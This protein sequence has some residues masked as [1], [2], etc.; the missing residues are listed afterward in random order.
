MKWWLLLVATCYAHSM[1]STFKTVHNGR[2]QYCMKWKQDGKWRYVYAYTR[3]E[4]NEKHL[5]R[6]NEIGMAGIVKPVKKQHTAPRVNKNNPSLK[7]VFNEYLEHTQLANK[8]YTQ[9]V[10]E[11]NNGFKRIEN[12]PIKTIDRETI[13]N[14]I[15]NK[16]LAPST[17]LHYHSLIN[18]IFNY[19]Y[20]H[21]IIKVKPVFEKPHYENKT[22]IKNNANIE[23]YFNTFM[24]LNA[25]AERIE[26][27]HWLVPIM[28]LMSLGLRIGEIL[29]LTR[30]SISNANETLTINKTLFNNSEI[31]A[32]SKGN[33]NTY[34]T[35]T[36]PL[37][38]EHYEMLMNIINNMNNE[39][40]ETIIWRNGEIFSHEHALFMH[41]NHV[42]KYSYFNREWHKIQCE[43]QHEIWNAKLTS[44]NYIK[45]HAPRHITASLMAMNGIPIQMAQAILGHMNASM[46]E[47]YTHITASMARET[48]NNYINNINTETS[49]NIINVMLNNNE[50]KISQKTRT[51]TIPTRANNHNHIT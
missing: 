12:L 7:M 35:R 11:F 29:A 45:P 32:G 41:R 16:K 21:G 51:R 43:Y 14:I 26:K 5:K 3:N 37:P 44:E 22:A 19:A 24:E 31:K 15:L 28:K 27:W 48:M 49:E 30:E 47:Y 50:K 8:T 40:S 1:A 33:A 20:K 2:E 39:N 42:M 23:N 18:A 17:A 46:T 10:H 36:I 34:N 13:E 38:H 9:R 25:Y 4:L 6:V